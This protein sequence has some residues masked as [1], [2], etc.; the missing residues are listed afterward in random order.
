[1]EISVICTN[2]GAAM[3]FDDTKE[4]MFC[5]QCGQKILRLSVLA[6]MNQKAPAAP[7]PMAPAA[8]SAGSNVAISYDSSMSNVRMTVN[9]GQG[10]PPENFISGKM[11]KFHFEPGL[12]T[13]T[14]VIGNRVYKRNINIVPG[15]PAY[16]IECG[17]CDGRA[18]IS[19]LQPSGGIIGS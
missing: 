8:R 6:A 18:Y 3:Q 2:C 10:I 12:H 14:F 13:I 15:G 4:H 17:W 19:I 5:W 1:M 7:R 16:K 11:K 9:F